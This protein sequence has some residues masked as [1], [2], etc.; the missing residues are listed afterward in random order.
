VHTSHVEDFTSLNCA[1][2]CLRS[3]CCFMSTHVFFRFSSFCSWMQG[4]RLSISYQYVP[5]WWLKKIVMQTKNFT[6][7]QLII[8]SFHRSK[9][10][11]KKGLKRIE[12]KVFFWEY[13]E[14]VAQSKKKKQCR[15]TKALRLQILYKKPLM[16]FYNGHS[17][18]EI[19]N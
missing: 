15:S 5:S 4:W 1:K 8:F 6:S 2:E 13:E 7:T 18:G 19:L 16:I 12:F 10:K 17:I 3:W 9:N 14:K 11:K